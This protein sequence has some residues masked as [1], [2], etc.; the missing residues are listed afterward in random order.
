MITKTK[1]HFEKISKREIITQSTQLLKNEIADVNTYYHTIAAGEK[2][3]LHSKLFVYHILFIISGKAVFS[4]NTNDEKPIKTHSLYAA[5]HS[6]AVTINAIENTYIF[7]IELN[8]SE[9]DIKNSMEYSSKFP[10]VQEYDKCQQYWD[11][12]KTHKTINRI[13]L[14]EE[15]IPRIAI[16]SVESIGPD[17]I[18][19]N[20]HPEIDQLFFTFPENETELIINDEKMNLDGNTLIHI[21]LGSNHGSNVSDGKHMHYIWCDFL[22][23]EKSLEQLQEGVIKI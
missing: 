10:I 22:I 16:G 23:N 1:I 11:A 4:T 12:S 5:N 7:E 15:Q 9:T 2:L 18:I 13:I 14:E 20:S 19:P 17:Y 21:P 6:E 3:E 8:A